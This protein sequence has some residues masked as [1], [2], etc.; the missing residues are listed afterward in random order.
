MTL[1]MLGL[2]GGLL[3]LIY[4]TLRGMNIL[5]AAPLCAL[6]VAT[7]SNIPLLPPLAEGGAS[8]TEN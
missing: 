5:I 6:L 2:I 8:F 3:L 7:R 1:S 4:L